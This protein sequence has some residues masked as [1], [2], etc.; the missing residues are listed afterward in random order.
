MERGSSWTGV[1]KGVPPDDLR[2]GGRWLRS[3]GRPVSVRTAALRGEAGKRGDSRG[4]QAARA[5]HFPVP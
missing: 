3:V 2:C 5:N 4:P 1:D